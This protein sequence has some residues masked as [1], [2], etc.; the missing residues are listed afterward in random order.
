MIFSLAQ[1]LMRR[2]CVCLYLI[3]SV[4]KPNYNPCVAPSG[5]DARVDFESCVTLIIEHEGGF[6]HDDDD[7]GGATK[8]GISQRAYPDL[9]IQRLTL[10]QAKDVYRKDYWDKYSVG[11]LPP[12]FRLVVFDALVNQGPTWTTK[13]LQ[14]LVGTKPDGVL[15]PKTVAAIKAFKDKQGL[16][17]KFMRLR[18]D[19]Y[20]SHPMYHKFGR[21]WMNRV[22]SL[23]FDG[24][25]SS[26]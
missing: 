19:R 22:V 4:L 16:L 12:M 21:G 25:F 15:G 8:Y 3:T 17:K 5:E 23:V 26:V 10:A 6:V 24:Y 14:N 11:H 18:I 9:V 1:R 2:R 13:G 7:L 20:H